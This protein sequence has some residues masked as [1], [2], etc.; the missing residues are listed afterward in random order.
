M[1]ARTGD[2]TGAGRPAFRAGH[3]ACLYM[4][5]R[6]DIHAQTQRHH[7]VHVANVVIV[8]HMTGLRFEVGDSP[9]PGQVIDMRLRL[10][11]FFVPE[12]PS[13]QPKSSI[14]I[15]QKF[16][17]SPS[18]AGLPALLDERWMRLGLSGTGKVQ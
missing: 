16:S 13:L 1:T 18:E 14:L 11:R 4:R 8:M 17:P 15:G 6:N 5:K 7:F 3:S 12:P 9:R 2:T 10:A